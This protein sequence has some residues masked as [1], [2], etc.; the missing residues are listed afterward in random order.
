MNNLDFLKKILMSDTHYWIVARQEHYSE[1]GSYKRG[2][3]SI[4]FVS[5]DYNIQL[6]K[7]YE[8]ITLADIEK[9]Q[10]SHVSNIALSEDYPPFQVGISMYNIY[11]GFPI[12]EV[13]GIKQV[14]MDAVNLKSKDFYEYESVIKKKQEPIQEIANQ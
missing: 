4:W 11:K 14:M 12:P 7:K 6:N 5:I 13:K 8:E 3:D 1:Y 9:L 2:A 10:S